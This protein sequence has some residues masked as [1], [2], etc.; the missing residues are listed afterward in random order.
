MA[1]STIDFLQEMEVE[2]EN[3]IG[4]VDENEKIK[5]ILKVWFTM[6]KTYNKEPW[7]SVANIIEDDLFYA[8][9]KI[10]LLTEA[11]KLSKFLIY[12]FSISLSL[13]TF[14]STCLADLDLSE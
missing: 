2:I 5:K 13:G 10:V 9:A 11:Q 12:F 7:C 6:L 1:Q 14:L 8:N 3:W 4:E